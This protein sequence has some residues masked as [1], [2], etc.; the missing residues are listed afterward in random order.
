MYFKKILN[1]TDN[2]LNS[3]NDIYN[4]INFFIIICCTKKYIKVT[5][6]SRQ[7]LNNGDLSFKIK[8]LYQ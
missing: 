6:V 7:K 3:Y 8:F 2:E 5:S 4:I 1:K